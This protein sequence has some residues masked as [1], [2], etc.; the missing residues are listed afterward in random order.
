VI[1][2]IH[3]ASITTANLDRLAAFYRDTLG[4]SE[5]LVTEWS[6]GNG[7]ADAIFGLR[8]T[9][10]RMVMLRAGNAFLELFEFIDPKGAPA[11]PGRRVNDCGI[12]HICV[13]VDDIDAEYARLTAA[14]M[15]FNAAPQD[16]PGLCRATYG[17]DPDGN[18]IELMQPEPG[19]PFAL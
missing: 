10:V 9:A 4:F 16:A 17:R 12:T 6:A 8:D 1:G 3:H 5:V 18:I 14:G 19:G 13:A 2:G 11:N 7:A 15:V